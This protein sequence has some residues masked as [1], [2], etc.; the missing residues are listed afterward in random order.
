M[1][2]KIQV[3]FS[4]FFTSVFCLGIHLLLGNLAVAQESNPPPSEPQSA[5]TEQGQEPRAEQLSPPDQENEINPAAQMSEMELMER[6]EELKRQLASQQY[7]ERDAA[8]KE[9][10]QYGPIVLD[11]LEFSEDEVSSDLTARLARIRKV[12]E[13]AAA[14]EA[15]RPSLVSISGNFS[16]EEIFK[17]IKQQTRNDVGLIEDSP[18]QLAEQ[19]IDIDLKAVEFWPAMKKIM[20]KSQ[21]EIAIFASAPGQLRLAPIS[22]SVDE[23]G[24]PIAPSKVEIPN[25]QAG[26]FD[27]QVTRIDSTRNLENPQNSYSN[28]FSKSAFLI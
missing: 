22:L 21:L 8:E 15:T 1:P 23:T 4:L 27:F 11:L 25:D 16:I 17:Q 5:A 20:K 7:P 13:K 2:T 18:D 6:V 10:V 14:A 3:C 28:L 9:L 24:A 19:K 12:L 26:I